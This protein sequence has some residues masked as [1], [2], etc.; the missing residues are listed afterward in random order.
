V[1]HD[2]Y[3]GF[4]FEAFWTNWPGFLKRF[5]ASQLHSGCYTASA[6]QA[7]TDGK[8]TETVEVKALQYLEDKLGDS[9]Y[10][11]VQLGK[12]ARVQESHSGRTG[13]ETVP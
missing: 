13:I 8:G 3:R 1:I 9:Q 12:G 6:C 5:G 11:F 2:F 4:R 10:C 7:P